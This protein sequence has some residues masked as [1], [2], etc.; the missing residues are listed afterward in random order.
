MLTQITASLNDLEFAREMVEEL[1]F[2]YGVKDVT[3]ESYTTFAN[4]MACQ[5]KKFLDL[6]PVKMAKH[7]F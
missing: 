3:Y 2:Q 4:N 5:K 7:N 1:A 6:L